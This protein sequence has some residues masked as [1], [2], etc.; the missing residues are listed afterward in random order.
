MLNRIGER[1]QPC[2]SPLPLL[3]SS[4]VLLPV[5][6][7]GFWFKYRF[8]ISFLSFHLT[9]FIFN[10]AI[11]FSNRV[12]LNAFSV[13]MK[14]ANTYFPFSIYLSPK[15][16]NTLMASCVRFPLLKA[17]YSS[18]CAS[19]SIVYLLLFSTRRRTFA[20][21]NIRLIFQ[22]SSHFFSVI[23]LWDGDY[24]AYKKV[25]WPSSLS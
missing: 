12:L 8:A 10:M 11:R 6:T 19:S 9:P 3:L 1:Q 20:A 7:L 17:Y 21:C 16:L 15:M 2:L 18:P 23:S 14:T 25:L 22:C 5:R 4:E 24:Y 13:S